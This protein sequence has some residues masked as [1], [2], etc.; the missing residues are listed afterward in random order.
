MSENFEKHL[1]AAVASVFETMLNM[2]PRLESL[3]EKFLDNE[4]HVAG[5]VG[6]T[7][8]LNGMVYIFVSAQFARRI[9]CAMIQITDADI[10]NDD[11]VNDVMGELTNMTAGNFKA[12][13]DTRSNP[14]MLT[15]P[16][17]VRG[18]NFNVAAVSGSTRKAAYLV[19][20]KDAILIEVIMKPTGEGQ[21]G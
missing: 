3:P 4:P 1:A 8:A 5:T 20:D 15:I 7:G 18:T 12:N 9:T 2:K 19:C 13:I 11:M 17:V 6:L 16:S 21:E 10:E 14:C